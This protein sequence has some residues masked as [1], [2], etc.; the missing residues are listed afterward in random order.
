MDNMV[1]P[2]GRDQK[3]KPSEHAAE[4]VSPN[5][6]TEDDGMCD[7][8][9]LHAMEDDEKMARKRVKVRIGRRNTRKRVQSLAPTYQAGVTWRTT[10]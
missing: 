6:S 2:A 8:G 3:S 9:Q 10:T 5:D 7:R 4:L 1:A